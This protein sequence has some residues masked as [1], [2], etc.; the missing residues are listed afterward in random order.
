MKTRIIGGFSVL[1]FIGVLA[2]SALIAQQPAQGAGAAQG[3]QGG[4]GGRAGG[5]G[6]FAPPAINWPDPPLP[7][8]PI[9]IQSAVPAHRDLGGTHS[10]TLRKSLDLPQHPL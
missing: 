6:G 7:D 1:A 10:P 9:M 3:R 4:Q 5:G 8:G 2:T